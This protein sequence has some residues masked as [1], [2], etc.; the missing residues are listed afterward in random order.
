MDNYL[1]SNRFRSLYQVNALKD[2]HILKETAKDAA[3][4][5]L[6]NFHTRS[7]FIS[8]MDSFIKSQIDGIR[9]SIRENECREFLSN[10]KKE[11]E[12]IDYQTF[13][14]MN[15]HAKIVASAQLAEV[16]HVLGYIINGVGVIVGTSQIVAGF[17]I[18]GGS[19]THFN[20]LG[21]FTGTLL[22]IHGFNSIQEGFENIKNG[23]N[24]STG[25][26]KEGYVK[27]AKFFGLDDKVGKLAYSSM[28]LTL[29]AYGLSRMILKKDAWRLF[30]YI[31]TDYIR[32][33]KV[34]GAPSLIIEA[35]GDGLSI[36]SG[37][38]SLGD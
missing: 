34:V 1:D 9:N 38:E 22:V 27:T 26:V 15:R 13:N 16:E 4:K 31:P 18:L 28:D 23:K 29:S 19:S 7:A 21:A 37:L 2:A 6:K 33:I 3:C 35:A 14:L 5:Y 32:N 20:V 25:I 24:D 8:E 36:K 30:K 11:K 12:L 10:L 17:V